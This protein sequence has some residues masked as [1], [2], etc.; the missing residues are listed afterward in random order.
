[1]SDECCKC[2][3]LV[4]KNIDICI[5]CYREYVKKEKTLEY[6]KKGNI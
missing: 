5:S 2:G 3:K 4:S 6:P 1:M